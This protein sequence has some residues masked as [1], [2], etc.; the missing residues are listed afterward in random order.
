MANPATN[1]DFKLASYA[2][3]V[4]A[5]ATLAS[6]GVSNPHPIWQPAVSR[7]K[8]GDN[9]GRLLGAPTVQWQWGFVKQDPRDALRV[10]CPGASAQVYIVTPTTETV[11]GVP[12]A[13]ARYL[14]QMWWPSPDIAEDPNTG[15]RLQFMI[16]FKQLI[17]A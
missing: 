17:S 12:N 4:G 14:A 8:L 15:R 3:G 2:G 10:F 7:I 6:L 1:V 11:A 9:S 13:S 16:L 5:L